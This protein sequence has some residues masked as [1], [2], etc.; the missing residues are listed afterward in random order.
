M[1]MT[2]KSR[3]QANLYK[4]KLNS[5]SSATRI[6]IT[7]SM[8]KLSCSSIATSATLLLLLN[9]IV[10]RQINAAPARVVINNRIRLLSYESGQFVTVD[11]KSGIV[12]ASSSDTDAA[13]LFTE[14]TVEASHLQRFRS[15]NAVDQYL[16]IVKDDTSVHYAVTPLQKD[17]SGQSGSS[18]GSSDDDSINGSGASELEMDSSSIEIFQNWRVDILNGPYS[19]IRIPVAE[20]VNCY[21]AFEY[22]GEPVA[23][24]CSISPDDARASISLEYV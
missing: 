2:Y 16:S 14:E 22:T 4:Y 5:L 19:T 23:D 24:P 9:N 18:S 1:K 6:M 8:Q 11:V 21:L 7:L 12:T 3:D 15:V 20:N 10:L 17:T 13:T